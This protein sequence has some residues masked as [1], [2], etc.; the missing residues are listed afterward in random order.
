MTT[1]T[2]H[3]APAAHAGPQV[4]PDTLETVRKLKTRHQR[5]LRQVTTV[6][7]ELESFLKDDDDM[8]KMC[9]TRKQEQEQGLAPPGARRM[10]LPPQPA[11]CL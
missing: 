3:R 10:N 7:D 1:E 2:S 5:L 9:L 8:A 11:T 4:R 6:R